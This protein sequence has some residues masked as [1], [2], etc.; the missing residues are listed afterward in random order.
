MK[1][2]CAVCDAGYLRLLP[3]LQSVWT[4]PRPTTPT[5]LRAELVSAFHYAPATMSTELPS[6]GMWGDVGQ[7]KGQDPH[8]RAQGSSD[9]QTLK[10][11]TPL[12]EAVA[13]KPYVPNLEIKL[14][15][16]AC[17]SSLEDD[18]RCENP[19]EVKADMA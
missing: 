12:R 10:K 7:P 8:A 14:E 5:T 15:L 9:V 6:A 4:L 3:S 18:F 17:F 13:G 16:C 19:N 11:W 2:G 1:S